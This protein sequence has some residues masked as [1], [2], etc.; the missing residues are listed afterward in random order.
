MRRLITILGKPDTAG[1]QRYRPTTYTFPDGRTSREHAFFGIALYQWWQA[2]KQG[3]IDELVVVGTPTSAWDALYELHPAIESDD[4]LAQVW[5]ELKERV[6]SQ[7]GASQHDLS[8][9]EHVLEHVLEHVSVRCVVVGECVEPE[10]QV[11][12]LHTLTHTM[13]S[14]DHVVLDLTH[15]YR[16]LG[17]IAF[18][19]L[20][21]AAHARGV[22]VD[23]VYYALFGKQA[24]AASLDGMQTLAAW[25][26]ALAIFRRTGVLGP[27]VP[28]MR[29]ISPQC[30]APLAALAYQLS[31]NTFDRAHLSWNQLRG[32]LTRE[33]D[34][35][36][37]LGMASGALLEEMTKIFGEGDAHL[38]DWQ[39]AISHKALESGDY[40]RA[41]LMLYEAV[42]SAAIYDVT[43]RSDSFLRQD[44][45]QALTSEKSPVQRECF[46][47]AHEFWI[48]KTLSF[49]RNTI[50]HG[51]NPLSGIRQN[52]EVLAALKSA[53]TLH[54]YLSATARELEPV[55]ERLRRAP[56]F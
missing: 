10:E 45:N 50:A 23:G 53:S 28:L 38:C 40:M 4:E 42:I 29:E 3:K 43:R 46:A 14:Q 44:V 36:G 26:E 32:Q 34:Q 37:I 20:L 13:R 49:V 30:A 24:R 47:D 15:G 54:A 21:F 48:F 56:P 27:L 1:T 7:T 12:L 22:C 2:G 18:E 8:A 17:L 5:L 41:A 6:D 11:A 35:P 16:H 39:L 9:V 52:R 31:I 25:S 19:A 55:I 51:S 33:R